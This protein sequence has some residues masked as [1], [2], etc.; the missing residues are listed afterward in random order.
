M[1]CVL[2]LAPHTDGGAILRHFKRDTTLALAG[3]K[4]VL[5]R[6]R[7]IDSSG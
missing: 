6:L 5:S 7:S 2:R 1:S 3:G 4:P